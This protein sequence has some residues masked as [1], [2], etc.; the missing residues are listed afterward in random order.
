MRQTGH[1]KRILLIVCVVIIG[2]LWFGYDKV[3]AAEVHSDTRKQLAAKEA[4]ERAWQLSSRL[5]TAWAQTLRANPAD[6]DVDI[7]VYDKTT[8]VTAHYT[9]A[10]PGTT[11]NSASIVKL[12]ILEELL[13]A[14]QSQG[15]TGLTSDQLS[16]AVPMIEN[17]DNDAATSLWSTVGGSTAMNGFFQKIGATDTLAETDSPWGLTQTTALDQLKVVNQLAYHTLLSSSSVTAMNNLLSN[18]E[19]DQRWG[20]TGGVSSNASVQLKNG[21]LAYDQGWNV[22]SIGHVH[23]D[24]TDY[25][26]AVLTDG[27]ATEQDGIDT[28]QA[29]SA[30]T[31][32]T[33]HTATH[34]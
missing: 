15:I 31:W 14:N 24:G 23:G 30:A 17:S 33:L 29:L 4:Q 25:T 21:W 6:G 22:N 11:Y 10:A 3:H 2:G 26:I 5:S 7:A 16:E 8:G 9:N 1:A 20:V 19:P 18:I 32:N 13:L 28:I 34:N 12:S 27:N